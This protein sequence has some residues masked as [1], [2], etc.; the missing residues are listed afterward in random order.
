MK[1]WT[2]LII[3]SLPYRPQVVSSES[4]KW[5]ELMLVIKCSRQHM[6]TLNILH[7]KVTLYTLRRFYQG[8]VVGP[9]MT[10]SL[11]QVAV[12]KQSKMLLCQGSCK[13]NRWHGIASLTGLSDKQYVLPILE[14]LAIAGPRLGEAYT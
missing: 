13:H 2:T 3:Q 14:Q 10:H 5:G 4:H 6:Q 12:D 7:C 11:I 8:C 1:V 9:N